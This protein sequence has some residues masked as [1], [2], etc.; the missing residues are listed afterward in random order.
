MKIKGTMAVA[1]SGSLGGTTASHNAGGYYLRSRNV[2]TNP[3]TPRQNDVRIALSSVVAAWTQILTP[4]QRADWNTFGANTPITDRLGDT[5]KISGIS[6]YVKANV[7]RV[8]AFFPRVDDAPT[9]FAL[10]NLSTLSVGGFAAGPPSQVDITFDNTDDWATAVGGGLLVYAGRPQNPSINF[11]RGPYQLA[12]S[13]DGAVIAPTSP[14]TIDLPFPVVAG[15]R[16]FL[17]LQATQ[18]DGRPSAETFLSLDA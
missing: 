2:P 8:Q 7:P 14:A 11:F 6:W 10:A 1:F 15:Q 5:I 4:A 18:A 13:I 16:I 3:N 12:G 17:R 9:V